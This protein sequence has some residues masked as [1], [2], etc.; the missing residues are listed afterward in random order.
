MAFFKIVDKDE[1]GNKIEYKTA[2]DLYGLINYV[3]KNSKYID[4]RNMHMCGSDTYV[5]QFLYT[6]S[7]KGAELKKRALH[8]I[9]SFDTAEWERNMSE[10][11]VYRCIGILCDVADRFGIENHQCVFGLHANT[12]HL[13]LHIVL[14][15]VNLVTKKIIHFGPHQLEEFRKELAK[16]LYMLYHI[17]LEGTSYIREDGRMSYGKD[18]I[19][20]YENY[21]FSW[22]KTS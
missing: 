21:M 14:N 18:N 9:L 20:L 6:Q 2:D 10:D 12:Q 4:T 8:C 3:I 1:M 22:E 16:D 5:H 7:C 13:H 15:P 19:G 17:A 11:K